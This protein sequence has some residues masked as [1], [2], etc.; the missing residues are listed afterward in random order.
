MK[1]ITA[2]K[3]PSNKEAV[4]NMVN[5]HQPVKIIN[6]KRPDIILIDANDYFNMVNKL[7]QLKE[8][9]LMP[10]ELTAE[11]GAKFIFMGEFKES[12]DMVCP[13]C[14]D[15]DDDEE[16]EECDGTMSVTVGWDTIKK[17]YALAVKKMAHKA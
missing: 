14:Y 2:T 4:Y 11:N 17:I 9:A 7:E 13:E 5:A 3:F 10:K 15:L 16:C 6:T 12:V 8:F 1:E